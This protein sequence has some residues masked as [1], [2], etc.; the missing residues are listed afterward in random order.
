LII[1]CPDANV[2]LARIEKQQRLDGRR[3]PLI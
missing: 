2:A 3:R 1:E